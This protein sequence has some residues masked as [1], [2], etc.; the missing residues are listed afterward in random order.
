MGVCYLRT[1]NATEA[2]KMVDI[3]EQRGAIRR[4]RLYKDLV[5]L[6]AD[7]QSSL[8][9][10]VV[11]L[12]REEAERLLKESA[13]LAQRRRYDEALERLARAKAL[14]VSLDT[15]IQQR[16][17]DLSERVQADKRHAIQQAEAQRRLEDAL[18]EGRRLLDEGKPTE[19][20]IRFDE[21]LAIDPRNAAAAEGK[22]EA[23][24][25][26][27]ASQSRRSEQPPTSEA[28]SS[29]TRASA[30]RPSRT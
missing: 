18:A 1:G 21:A 6:R 5:K 25:R 2:L 4:S 30:R 16:V 27:L 3:E 9:E 14:A 7:A 28:R 17:S 13:D 20:A 19:A 29:S 10:R 11:Q 22:Q 26:L 23:R 15:A 8:T 12:A 24:Q